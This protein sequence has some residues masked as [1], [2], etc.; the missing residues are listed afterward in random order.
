MVDGVTAMCLERES[1]E[2][3]RCASAAILEEVG[4]ASYDLYDRAGTVYLSNMAA[5][6]SRADA[7]TAALEPIAAELGIGT[8]QLM[9]RTNEIGSAHREAMKTCAM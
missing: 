1:K 5:G 9:S 4:A 6:Q 3:C 2:V 8:I 7:W